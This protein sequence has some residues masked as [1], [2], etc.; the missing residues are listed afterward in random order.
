MCG[1]A[2]AFFDIALKDVYSEVCLTATVAPLGEI[3]LRFDAF[4]LWRLRASHQ[5]YWLFVA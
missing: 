4:L 1:H 2:Q 3:S 5:I